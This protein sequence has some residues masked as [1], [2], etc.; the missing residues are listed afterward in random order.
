MGAW[1]LSC[2]QRKR[3][4]AAVLLGLGFG[5]MAWVH[6]FEFVFGM[7]TLMLLA[8]T[9]WLWRPSPER[10]W[11]LSLAFLS[12]LPVGASVTISVTRANTTGRVF[13]LTIRAGKPPAAEVACSAPGSSKPSRC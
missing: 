5:L 9:A 3:P 4:L 1:S 12:S 6:P 13:E 10:R 7:S 8:G 2:S 11:N